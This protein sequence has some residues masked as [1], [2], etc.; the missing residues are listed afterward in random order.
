ML[1]KLVKR[2]PRGKEVTARVLLA[3]LLALGVILLISPAADAF[4]PEVRVILIILLCYE[5]Y[6]LLDGVPRNTLSEVYVELAEGRPMIPFVVGAGM[7]GWVM[8]LA[9]G[10]IHGFRVFT[11][12]DLAAVA[13]MCILMGHL[14]WQFKQAK[15]RLR[16][17]RAAALGVAAGVLHG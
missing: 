14:N 3:A 9:S 15:K 16:I 10:M 1:S 6:S 2:L 5:I 13:I 12:E 7:G 8:Y 17:R 11:V 4:W